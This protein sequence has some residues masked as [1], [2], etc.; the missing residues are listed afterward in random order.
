MLHFTLSQHWFPG[1]YS[2]APALVFLIGG[3]NRAVI[4][5]WFDRTV[6]EAF[7]EY[8]FQPMTWQYLIHWSGK[9]K[10]I[11]D[12]KN[13]SLIK[14]SVFFS[15]RELTIFILEMWIDCPIETL[16]LYFLWSWAWDTYFSKSEVDSPIK[17][18]SLYFHLYQVPRE[19]SHLLA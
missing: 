14:T 16:S 6:Q 4:C 2:H 19:G 18:S 1:R 9:T 13:D 17:T 10:L 7:L 8:H 3:T 12:A 11:I 5:C 15:D